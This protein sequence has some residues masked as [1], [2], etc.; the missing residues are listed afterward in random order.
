MVY[1]V[2][3]GFIILKIEDNTLQKVII[4]DMGFTIVL[5]MLVPQ[6]TV[7]S[8]NLDIIT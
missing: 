6:Y 3:S 7:S 8:G 1:L 5:P 4:T 2:S